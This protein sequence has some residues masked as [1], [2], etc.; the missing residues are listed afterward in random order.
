M[1]PRWVLATLASLYWRVR[2]NYKKAL[3]CLDFALR[4]VQN[5]E[6]A[7][8]ILVSI[9][10]VTHQLGYTDDAIKFAIQAFQR[11]EVD[12]STNFLLA[13]LHYKKNKPLL[14]LFY[15]KNAL[16]MDRNY[17][18]GR[19]EELLKIWSCRLKLGA[20][21]DVQN[22]VRQKVDK[23]CTEKTKVNEEAGEAVFCSLKGENCR[24]AAVQCFQRDSV[25]DSHGK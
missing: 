13:L 19:A 9:A 17:Y 12:P 11:S 14:A 8:P 18:D 7:E 6:R 2:G 22:S 10:S 23:T 1:A 20:F 16:R 25:S 4:N 5:H 3:T 24:T 15:L 21:P